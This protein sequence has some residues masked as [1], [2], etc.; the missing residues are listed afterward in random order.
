MPSFVSRGNNNY[1]L[2]VCRLHRTRYRLFGGGGFGLG[3]PVVSAWSLVRAS[4]ASSL[5][6]DLPYAPR[7]M[8]IAP[9]LSCVIMSVETERKSARFAGACAFNESAVTPSER[10]EGRVDSQSPPLQR[11][12]K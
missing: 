9:L 10:H 3:T 11:G 5:H 6:F 4:W 12:P 2:T 1:A 8:S 7:P